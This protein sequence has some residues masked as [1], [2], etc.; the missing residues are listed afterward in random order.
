MNITKLKESYSQGKID[1]PDYISAMHD[2]HTVL[3]EFAEFIRTTDIQKIEITDGQV[4]MTSREFGIK[5]L[6]DPKDRRIAPIEALNF[7]NYEKVECDMILRLVEDGQNIFDIG[8][9]FGWYSLV[10]ARSRHANVYT[11][12]PIPRTFGYLQRNVALNNLDG[13]KLFNFG[14]SDQDQELNFFYYPEGSGNASLAN[15]SGT[16]GVQS[17]KCTVRK[18]DDFVKEN[19][20]RIDFIKCDV[21]GAELLVFKGGIESIRR[22]K[23]IVFAELLRKWSAKFNYHPNE[24]IELFRSCGYRCFTAH[25]DKLVEFDN[26]DDQTVE[27]NFFFLHEEKHSDKIK[28]FCR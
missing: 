25:E 8:G 19:G 17:V 22:D 12:E 20:S 23:P 16:E 10:I 1:K 26:M 13:I 9:N 2:C 6:C 21:E 24:V 4:V 11:F 27:T 18:L 3:Y 7:D 15:L 14:F 28:R 5:M